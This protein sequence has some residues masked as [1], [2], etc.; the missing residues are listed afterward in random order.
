M[1]ALHFFFHFAI[2]S[3]HIS[4]PALKYYLE[5]VLLI[6]FL[7]KV[8]FIL[9]A[10]FY[11]NTSLLSEKITETQSHIPEYS[12]G[13]LSFHSQETLVQDTMKK[14]GYTKVP[15]QSS[16]ESMAFLF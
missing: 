10:Q 12:H 15:L 9:S 8:H 5:L 6:L 1:T 4:P 16:L 14:L 7:R 3:R 13:S 2:M 11:V